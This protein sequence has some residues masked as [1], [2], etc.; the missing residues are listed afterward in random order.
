MQRHFKY[1]C[2]LFIACEKRAFTTEKIAV[3]NNKVDKKAE[4][5]CILAN[6][7]M[8]DRD[9]IVTRWKINGN[10]KRIFP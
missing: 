8:N 6:E 4:S 9:K 5:Q 1:F 2:V 3:F 10:K 7:W